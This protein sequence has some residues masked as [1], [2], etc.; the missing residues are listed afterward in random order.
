MEE[1]ERNIARIRAG[2]ARS[3]EAET[4][5]SHFREADRILEHYRSGTTHADTL[6]TVLSIGVEKLLKLTYGLIVEDRDGSWPSK[7]EM[8]AVGHDVSGLEA[9]CRS[10]LRARVQLAAQPGYIGGL[11]DDLD[12][13]AH[14]PKLMMIL[15]KYGK[16]GRFAQLDYLSGQPQQGDSPRQMWDQYDT[17]LA[18]EPTALP[19]TTAISSEDFRRL[20]RT[21]LNTRHREIIDRWR[22]VYFRA[23]I[24]GVAGQDAKA[25]GWEFKPGLPYDPDGDRRRAVEQAREQAD[26]HP[27][28]R[29]FRSAVDAGADCASL[30]AIRD[31]LAPKDT[32]KLVVNEDL[33]SIGC[34]SRGSTRR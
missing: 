1:R 2:V 11:L 33:R 15:T 22:E 8:R 27:V 10:L 21:P 19:L 23:L 18:S 12:A 28:Y 32:V 16:A 30:F 5:V 6:L 31:E 3:Y 7:A 34:F 13:D 25:L 9:T 4:V 17:Q 20:V 24:H 26:S 14:V 29:R